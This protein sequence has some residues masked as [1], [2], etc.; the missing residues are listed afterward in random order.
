LI[1]EQRSKKRGTLV[2]SKDNEF[3]REIGE[4]FPGDTVST[5]VMD[6]ADVRAI[7]AEATLHGT[8]F[9]LCV[10]D[11]EQTK[12]D[13]R[14]LGSFSVSNAVL[15]AAGAHVLGIGIGHIKAGLEAVVRIPGRFEAFGGGSRPLVI[16][17]YSHTPDSLERTLSFCLDLTP[18]RLITVFGCGGDRDRG[19]RP[20]MGRIAQRLSDVCYVTSD[21]PRSED[22]RRIIDDILAGMSPDRETVFVEIERRTAI[23]EAIN[24]ARPGDLVSICGKGHED[25]QIIGT[26]RTHLDDREEAEKALRQWGVN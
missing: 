23:R 21:N 1:S 6:P 13:L 11:E 8:R 3:S 12:V 7:D 10:G 22:P 18:D 16:I 24:A 4:T 9:I 15:A 19:K 17:D 2:Y 20:I 14:L 25:Y 26:T 5:S